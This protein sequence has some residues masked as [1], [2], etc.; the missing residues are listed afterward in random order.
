L[1]ID[2]NLTIAGPGPMFLIIGRAVDPST[3]AFRILEIA[4]GV[5]VTIEGATIA[6]GRLGN[7]QDGAGI[8]NAGTLTLRNTASDRNSCEGAGCFRGAGISSVGP[9]T[10]IG[11]VISNNS[12]AVNGG[13]IW[14]SGPLTIRQSTISNN[15][16]R[17]LGGGIETRG[18]ATVESS[19]F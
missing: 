4:A 8:R 10:V 12:S 14:A 16:A 11:S 9:L 7:G 2:K 5:T 1:T 13:G 17:Q 18:G 19:L 3:P 15:A 6:N